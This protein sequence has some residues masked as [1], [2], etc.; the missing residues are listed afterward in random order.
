M[1]SWSWFLVLSVI[2]FFSGAT[3][4]E[5]HVVAQLYS[6]FSQQEDEWSLWITFDIGLAEEGSLGPEV[7]QKPREYLFTLSEEEHAEL[8]KKTAEILRQDVKM[9]S[10]D[11]EISFPDYDS[12]PYSFPELRVGGAYLNVKL[13]GEISR[14][15]GLVIRVEDSICPRFVVNLGGEFYNVWKGDELTLLES[16]GEV[17]TKGFD[18]FG[19]LKVGFEHVLPAGWDHVLF[20]VGL[21]LLQVKLRPVL[22]QSLAFTLAHS[23]TLALAVHCVLPAG[24]KWIEVLIA[25]SIA[26]VGISSLKENELGTKRLLFVFIFGLIHGMGFAGALAEPLQQSD[27]FIPALASLNLGVELAQ[28]VVGLAVFALFRVIPRERGR[29][30]LALL[31]VVIGSVLTLMRIFS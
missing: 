20:V 31:I 2:C 1:R 17:G 8:R 15:E 3:V 4:S 30:V 26:G 9:T 29:Q 11:Y 23:L 28:L 24:G 25:A 5:A 7:P 14:G 6:K 21:C 13:S 22:W 18:F 19:F 16:S 27:Q 12:N 10:G